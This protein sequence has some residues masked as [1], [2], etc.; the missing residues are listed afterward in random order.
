MVAFSKERGGLCF[1]RGPPSG[2]LMRSQP[3]AARRPAVH[4]P[5]VKQART[6]SVHSPA[7]CCLRLPTNASLQLGELGLS[8]DWMI[9][10]ERD[11]QVVGTCGEANLSR[12]P[13]RFEP[14]VSV[15]SEESSNRVPRQIATPPRSGQGPRREV[16]WEGVEYSQAEQ[17]RLTYRACL[18][19]GLGACYYTLR[20][21]RMRATMRPP[22]PGICS[23]ISLDP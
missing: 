16:C 23:G 14:Q 7:P 6:S 22:I 21:M 5:L 17:P 4:S 15:F 9:R 8:S 10:R 13:P 18:P 20:R 19:A 3:P 11:M 12:P 1:P 2:L